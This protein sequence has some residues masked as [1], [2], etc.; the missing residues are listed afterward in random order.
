MK[1][2]ALNLIKGH[3]LISLSHNLK[4]CFAF[5]FVKLFNPCDKLADFQLLDASTSQPCHLRGYF[6]IPT[7]KAWIKIKPA[8]TRTN[9]L[10]IESNNLTILTNG[11]GGIITSVCICEENFPGLDGRFTL[12]AIVC[13]VS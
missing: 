7:R 10:H 11:A 2:L 4:Y 8:F 1:S 9:D 13:C 3:F 6:E 12:L 5:G